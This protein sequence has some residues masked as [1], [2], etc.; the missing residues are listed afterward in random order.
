M[1]T[2]PCSA[3]TMFSRI[4]IP[5][6]GSA[7]SADT[8]MAGIRFA[9]K[10]E[11]DVVGVFVAPAFQYPLFIQT[12]PPSYLS[13]EEYRASMQ[14]VGDTYLSEIGRAASVAGLKFSGEVVFSD[15]VAT[16]IIE[17]ARKN[18]CDL[19]FIGS[20]GRGGCDHVYLGSVTLKLLSASPLPVLVYRSNP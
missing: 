20:H 2:H 1:S 16:A 15:A 13:A 18:H 10:F 14:T 17:A 7:A 8:A 11:A 4:L 19:I 6:D 9:R 12:M 5:T 3:D